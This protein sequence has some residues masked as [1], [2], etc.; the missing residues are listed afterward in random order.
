MYYNT[1]RKLDLKDYILPFTEHQEKAKLWGREG[2]QTAL[3]LHCG[4]YNAKHLAKFLELYTS[5][6][7][8]FIYSR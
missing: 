5:Q 7:E 1:R 4:S 6:S 8:Y 2:D 3:Y